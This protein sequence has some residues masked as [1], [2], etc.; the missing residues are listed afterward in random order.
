[1]SL[2]EQLQIELNQL[3]PLANQPTT[4]QVTDADS[5]LDVEL[6]AADQLAIS[7]TKFSLQLPRLAGAS[8][9]TLQ[10]T[11]DAHA[12]LP[13]LLTLPEVSRLRRR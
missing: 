3:G 10:K 4:V 13:S 6:T 11:T 2:K 5:S 1:M 9:A 7:F 8:K 12:L